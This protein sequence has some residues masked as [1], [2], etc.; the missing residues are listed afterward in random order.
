MSEVY[1]ELKP[2]TL[3]YKNKLRSVGDMRKTGERLDLLVERFGYGILGLLPLPAGEL[4]GQPVLTI[5]KQIVSHIISYV[6]RVAE[7][8]RFLSIPNSTFKGFVLRLDQLQGDVL[9]ATSKAVSKVVKAIFQGELDRPTSF[10]IERPGQ[11]QIVEYPRGSQKLLR[12][13]S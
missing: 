13:I 4:T 3:E 5:S 10:G 11:T 8:S 7:Y 2:N 9:R 6:T 1:P 12:L